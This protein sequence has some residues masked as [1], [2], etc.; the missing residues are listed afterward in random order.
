MLEDRWVLVVTA[1]DRQDKLG[2]RLTD[3]AMF[4]QARIRVRLSGVAHSLSLWPR[5]RREELVGAGKTVL[6]SDETG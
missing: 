1:R 5:N 6:A 2:W 3:T 4:S